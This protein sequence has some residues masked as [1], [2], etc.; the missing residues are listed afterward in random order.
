[1]EKSINDTI[2]RLSETEVRILREKTALAAAI[3]TQ[4]ILQLLVSKGVCT[5]QEVTS[6][7]ML[8]SAQEKYKG[9]SDKLNDDLGFVRSQ[10]KNLNSMKRYLEGSA[11]DEDIKNIESAMHEVMDI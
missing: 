7:R 8:V 2:E 1:M 11:T 6:V 3:D 5:R 10:L 9:I 4:A